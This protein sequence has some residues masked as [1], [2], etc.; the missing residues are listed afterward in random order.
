VSTGMASIQEIDECVL[1][2]KTEWKR[3][4]PEKPSPG[5]CILRCV[6]AYPT[7]I[8]DCNLRT[9]PH[10]GQTWNVVPG[11]SDHTLTTATSVAAVA[12]GARCIEK[13]ITVARSLGG[14]DSTFSIEPDEFKKMMEDVRIAE[15]AMGTVHYGGSEGEVRI[16]RRSIFV[17]KD[18][19]K[20]EQFQELTS[21]ENGGNGN[22]RS[23][24]PGNGLHSR[25]MSD[26]VGKYARVDISKGTPMDWEL[27][28]STSVEES[29]EPT[30]KKQK[31]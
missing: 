2:L 6:S 24:R 22:V 16:F 29:D 8:E 15:A 12:L 9:I 10:I 28:T 13:H 21:F 4:F 17:T 5:I 7:K 23:I 26:I 20:G 25:H 31:K 30:A 27:M 1:C 19:K 18:M 3:L 11:L 14:P